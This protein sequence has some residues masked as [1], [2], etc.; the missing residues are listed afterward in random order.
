MLLLTHIFSTL[1]CTQRDLAQ[2]LGISEE[3]VSR[4]LHGTRV[5]RADRRA[6][7]KAFL[8]GAGIAASDLDVYCANTW[9]G[10]K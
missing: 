5:P 6:E 10:V 1:G 9:G 4:Y 2:R 3:T 8:L 7:I